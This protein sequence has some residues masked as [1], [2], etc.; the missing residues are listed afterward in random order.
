MRK[1]KVYLNK[2]CTLY[3]LMLKAITSLD[4]AWQTDE[5]KEMCYRVIKQNPEDTDTIRSIIDE[6]VEVICRIPEEAI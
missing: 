2:P 1:P 3:E 6:Y 5:A 4:N